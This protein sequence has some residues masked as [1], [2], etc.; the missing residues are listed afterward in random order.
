M[1]RTHRR[2][3]DLTQAVLAEKADVSVEMIS[4]IEQGTAAPSFETLEK[5][6]KA[7]DTPVHEFFISGSYAANS[8]RSG[9]LQRIVSRISHLDTEELKAVED[10][11]AAAL[12][13]KR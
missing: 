3:R 9:P 13:L 8:K 1:V 4:R 11:I 12:R 10:F 6:S 7:L 5:I 2:G